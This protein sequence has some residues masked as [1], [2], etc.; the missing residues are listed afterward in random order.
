M[1]NI[2]TYGSETASKDLNSGEP[3]EGARALGALP[4]L[5]DFAFLNSNIRKVT[6]MKETAYFVGKIA[7]G[8]SEMLPSEASPGEDGDGE[9]L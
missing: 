8:K 1:K 2:S 5:C 4:A 6:V 7:D 3:G 9:T